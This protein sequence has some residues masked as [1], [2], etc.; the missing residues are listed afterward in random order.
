MRKYKLSWPTG[1]GFL[2]ITLKARETKE[3]TRLDYN[4]IKFFSTIKRPC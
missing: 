4:K 1:N 3:K 2:D